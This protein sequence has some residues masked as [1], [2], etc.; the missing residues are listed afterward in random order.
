MTVVSSRDFNRD[1]SAAKRAASKGPVV[2]TDR[3]EPAFVLLS[4]DD[5]RRL[6]GTDSEDSAEFLDRLQLDE[7]IDVEFPQMD[8]TLKAPDF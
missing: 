1:V 7:V 3:G 2:V 5:Y 8:I 4:I 6:T